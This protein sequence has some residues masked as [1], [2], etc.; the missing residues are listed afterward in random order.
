[1][2]LI[3][4]SLVAWLAVVA[5]CASTGSAAV[6]SVGPG[7][8]YSTVQA[9]VNAASNGDTIEI[10]SGTYV[11]SQGNA[12]IGKSSL[13]L[14]GVGETRPILDAGGT[15]TGGKAIWVIAGSNTTIEFVEF[16]NCTVPDKNGA[17]ITGGFF[18]HDGCR[19]T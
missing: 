19:L 4:R 11:G 5:V 13:T 9:A 14:R 12:W 17:G 3:S 8:T 10:H 7:Q 18:S 16:Q 2:C 1:M 15:S 6:L